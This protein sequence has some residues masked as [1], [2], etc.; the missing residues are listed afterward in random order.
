MQKNELYSGFSKV[1]KNRKFIDAQGKVLY[2]GSTGIKV[3]P[4]VW[5][6]RRINGKKHWSIKRKI[7]EVRVS[8]KNLP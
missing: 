4:N 1:F 5:G 7:H 3:N 2:L 6:I 8:E